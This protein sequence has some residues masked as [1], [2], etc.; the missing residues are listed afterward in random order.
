MKISYFGYNGFVVEEGDVKVAI[1]PGASLYLF[2]LGPVIPKEL[3]PSITHVVVTHGDPD[4][5]WHADRV[6]AA[7]DAPIVCGSELV[8]VRNNQSY[9]ASPRSR[10]FKYSTPVKRAIPMKHG[11]SVTV[12]GVRFE[13]YPSVHGDLKLRLL[14]GLLRKTVRREPNSLFAKGETAFVFEL[15]GLRIANL[16]DTIKLD[17]W[18][19]IN[20]D[21]LMVPI[22][23]KL[24][25][26]TMDEESAADLVAELNPQFV[27][28]CH[29]DCAAFFNPRL[30][31]AD[32]KTFA[33][34]VRQAGSECVV[35]EPGMSFDPGVV[36]AR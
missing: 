26:N 4:H 18:E 12:D 10:T 30:N 34:K 17:S 25:I 11:E 8:D 13:A 28:P 7:A 3:W 19:G 9:I 20:A 6:A 2:N 29:Y 24:A 35:M 21:I 36:A 27:I 1:D 16:G 33:R 32:V 31:K 23:G 5:Y 14:G 15:G 22:G